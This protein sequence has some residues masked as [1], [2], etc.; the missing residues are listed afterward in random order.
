MAG[1]TVD[2][3]M[4]HSEPDRLHNQEHLANLRRRLS[5]FWN[6]PAVRRASEPLASIPAHVT[7][8]P[9][10]VVRQYSERLLQ[11]ELAVGEA[12]LGRLVGRWTTRGSQIASIEGGGNPLPDEEHLVVVTIATTTTTARGVTS[13]THVAVL[14]TPEVQ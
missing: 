5:E 14:E 10:D 4:L 8:S 1:V 12:P 13:E 2:D 9:R 7:Y 11:S 3:E 6:N